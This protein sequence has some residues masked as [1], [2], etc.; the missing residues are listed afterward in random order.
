MVAKEV[1]ITNS[2]SGAG[3]RDRQYE[4][5]VPERHIFGVSC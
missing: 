4:S 1:K 3:N 5:V 2:G